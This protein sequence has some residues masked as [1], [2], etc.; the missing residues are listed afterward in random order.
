MFCLLNC[1]RI[2]NVEFIF[3]SPAERELVPVL[4]KAK[5]TCIYSH[6]KIVNISARFLQ[7]RI[8]PQVYFYVFE[9]KFEIDD[10]KC[11]KT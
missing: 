3:E 2:S 9:K 8:F 11:H 7:Q 1:L 6:E 10:T 4:R 5:W